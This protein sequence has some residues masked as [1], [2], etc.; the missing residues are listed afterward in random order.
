MSLA[1]RF[2]APQISDNSCVILTVSKTLYESFSA[3]LI[4][5]SL[6]GISSFQLSS[7]SSASVKIMT[8]TFAE[9]TDGV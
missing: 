8:A 9:I 2:F 1:V 5:Y 7:F 4:A 6:T 3:T